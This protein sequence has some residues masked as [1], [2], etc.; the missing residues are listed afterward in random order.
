MPKAQYIALLAYLQLAAFAAETKQ[1]AI[2]NWQ[3]AISTE[4]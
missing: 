1:L 2:S 3:L 4:G